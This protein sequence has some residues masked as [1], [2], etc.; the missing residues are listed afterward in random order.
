M[1]GVQY[2]RVRGALDREGVAKRVSSRSKYG[3]AYKKDA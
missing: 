2:K 1:P 3:T